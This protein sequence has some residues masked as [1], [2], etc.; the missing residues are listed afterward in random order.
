M[1]RFL[2]LWASY[3][4][5]SDQDILFYQSLP[6]EQQINTSMLGMVDSHMRKIGRVIIFFIMP[7]TLVNSINQ[8]H[9]VGK[10]KR[11]ATLT[12]DPYSDKVSSSMMIVT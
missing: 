11:E 5:P 8:L 6:A 2:C 4:N 1:L 12:T 3:S 10:D 7:N 9:N